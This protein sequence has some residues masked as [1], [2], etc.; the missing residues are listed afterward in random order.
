MSLPHSAP[1][2]L[3][4]GVKV[5]LRDG[6]KLN[7]TLYLPRLLQ[8]PA[9]CLLSV[10]PYVSD[11]YHDEGVYFAARGFPFL[12]VDA[13]GRGNSEGAFS[14]GIQEARDGYDLVEWL[15]TQ[16]YCSGQVAMFGGSYSGYAQWATAKELPPHLVAIAPIAATFYGLHAPMRNN[17]FYPERLRWLLLTSGHVQRTK[18]YADGAF[19]S[20][21]GRRWHESGRSFREFDSMASKSSACFQ[22][23][24]DHPQPDSFWDSYNPTPDQYA[25]ID[26]P[27]LTVTGS[28]DVD[29]PGALEHYRQHVASHSARG[30]SHFLVIGPWN[31]LAAQRPRAQFGGLTCGAASVLDLRLLHA[32]WYEWVLKRGPRPQ[33]LHKNVAY[34]VTGSERWRYAD[35]LD[36]VTARHEPH[37]LESAGNANDVF[38]SGWLQNTAGSGPPDSY[39]YDP[40]AT[41]GLEVDAE[42]SADDQSLFDQSLVLALRGR[43]LVYHSQP[44]EEEREISGFFRLSAW[45]SIDCPDTDLYVS[46]YVVD[47]NGAALILATDLM[48]V[49]YRRGL[50]HPRL[51]ETPEPL[52]YEFGSFTFVSRLIERGHRLRLVIAPV[53]RIDMVFVQKNYNGGGVVADESAAD[54]RAVTVKLFHDKAHP[55]ALYVPLGQGERSA[56]PG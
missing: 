11:L 53:G 29:Q 7:A 2:T 40:A 38:R 37:F 35:S 6:V 19:W 30:S 39:R 54:A 25:H 14:P 56:N 49:R 3:Q 46:V 13:R 18:L 17:V 27:V 47:P 42:A 34:Y 23:W 10:I 8:A 16:S 9:A 51:I 50:R 36:E 21:V 1:V 52:L 41:H 15:S 12:V 48:R 22:E 33:F 5:A 20:A 44:F 28:Y 32:Q 55:S 31:H 45:L 26:I 24:L 43:Q 4:W